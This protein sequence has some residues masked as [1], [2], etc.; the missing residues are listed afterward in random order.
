MCFDSVFPEVNGKTHVTSFFPH[1]K[2]SIHSSFVFDFVNHQVSL[3]LSWEESRILMAMG[4]LLIGDCI[5]IE[6]VV[7]SEFFE[8][9]NNRFSKQS[10]GN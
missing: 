8:N 2:T 3:C 9:K 10:S 4:V 5:E 7:A 6:I 1:V